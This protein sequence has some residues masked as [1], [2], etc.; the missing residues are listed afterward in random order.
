[1]NE[2][3]LNEIAALDIALKK[4]YGHGTTMKDISEMPQE[5][6]GLPFETVAYMLNG[7]HKAVNVLNRAGVVYIQPIKPKL[8]FT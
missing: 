5:L 3:T 8:I 6:Y 4:H 7:E 1:M 2:M